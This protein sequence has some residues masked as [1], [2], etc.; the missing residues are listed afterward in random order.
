MFTRLTLMFPLMLALLTASA[1]AGPLVYV[2]TFNGQFGAPTP[3]EFGSIDPTTG[4]YTQIGPSLADPLGGLVLGPNGY[5]G[6]SFSGNL[7]S[8]NPATGAITVL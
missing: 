4:V 3:G 5:I 6:V 7:D 2:V 1:N 8:V